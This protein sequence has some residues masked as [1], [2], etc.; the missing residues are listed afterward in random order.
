MRNVR[1][2][3]G[4]ILFFEEENAVR[5][6]YDLSKVSFVVS[7]LLAFVFLSDPYRKFLSSSCLLFTVSQVFCCCCCLCR[8]WKQGG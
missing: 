2:G 5:T 7:S 6:M 3:F 8:G 4:L 1:Q